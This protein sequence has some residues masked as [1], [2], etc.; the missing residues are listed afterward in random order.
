MSTRENRFSGRAIGLASVLLGAGLFSCKAIFIKLAY[1]YEVTSIELLGLRMLFALPFFL[2]IGLWQLRRTSTREGADAGGK[3]IGGKQSIWQPATFLLIAVIGATGYYFASYLDFLG[4][5]YVSAGM[6]RIILFTY[7]TMV[8]LLQRMIFKTPIRRVQWIATGLCYLGIGVAF[9]G[10][11]FSIGNQFTLGAGLILASALAYSFYVIG[12]GWLIRRVGNVE[13]T[14][15]ALTVASVAALTHVLFSGN[16]LLGLV[17]AVY[18]YGFT[19]GLL[20]TVIPSY[21]VSEGIKRLGPGDA[22]IVM[23]IGPVATI[24]LE[25][26]VLGEVMNWLQALGGALII[27][28]VVVI[29]RSKV[30]RAAAS[31]SPSPPAS[32]PEERKLMRG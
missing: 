29:G 21:L 27:V 25:Y 30:P 12:S 20:C 31:A 18:V 11:D 26:V 17:P 22:V 28:G 14:T 6:E 1:R 19:M 24:V 16:T 9:S 7:P 10:S 8:L 23:A 2:A 3:G 13:F 4:L 15:P 32:A 5:Q